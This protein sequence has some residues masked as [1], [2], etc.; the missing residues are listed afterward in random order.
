MLRCSGYSIGVCAIDAHRVYITKPD[1]EPYEYEVMCSE[2]EAFRNARDE[3]YKH[4]AAAED[5]T[6]SEG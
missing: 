6:E 5:E 2:A 3:V 1:G 4:M